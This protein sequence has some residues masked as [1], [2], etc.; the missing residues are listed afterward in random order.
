MTQQTYRFED[1][2]YSCNRCGLCHPCSPLMQVQNLESSTARGKIRLARCYVQGEVEAS[3]TLIDRIYECLLCG[4]CSRVCPA[5]IK[6]EEVMQSTRRTLASSGKTPPQIRRIVSNIELTGNI[7]GDA[8]AEKPSKING[9]LVYF[10]GCVS[11]IKH[12]DLAEAV[13]KSLSKAGL[14]VEVVDGVCCGA[15]AW[16][17]GYNEVYE[18]RCELLQGILEGKSVI[19]NCPHCQYFL[20]RLRNVEVKHVSQIYVD[21]IDAGRLKPGKVQEATVTYS[22]PCYL[23]RFLNIIDEPRRVLLSL[24]GLRL[25]EM[26]SRGENTKCCGNGFELVQN[27]YPELASK[28]AGNRLKDALNIGAG[29]VVTSCPH[30]QVTLGGAA[31]ER[32]L[33]LEVIDLSQLLLKACP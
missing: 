6:V 19:T 33:N 28:L 8:A 7:Y 14:N 1:A 20:R 22:D 30:C 18:K 32:S 31:R 17:A 12:R 29:V 3:R 21:L 27:C 24:D 26:E 15:P 13:L 2:L 11:S 23:A 5:G 10:P 16:A 4:H 9:D 25:V